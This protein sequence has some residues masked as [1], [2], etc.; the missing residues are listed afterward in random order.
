MRKGVMKKRIQQTTLIIPIMGII[1]FVGMIC[2]FTNCIKYFI[3]HHLNLGDD[4]ED[5]IN[6][7]RIAR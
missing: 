2:L 3:V 1:S 4:K 7:F 5:Y 6:E